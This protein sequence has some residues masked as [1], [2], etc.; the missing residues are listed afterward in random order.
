MTAQGK[1]RGDKVKPVE[2]TAAEVLAVLKK[3][4]T[5]TMTPER[6]AIF[7]EQKIGTGFGRT[8]AQAMDAWVIF[9]WP[10][11]RNLRMA[12]EIKVSRSDFKA[13]IKNPAK[14]R[15]ALQ[16][17][18]EFWFL[19]PAGL[20]KPEEIPLDCGLMEVREY[21]GPGPNAKELILDPVVSAPTLDTCPPSWNFVAALARRITRLERKP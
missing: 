8:A 21:G 15:P 14:R 18:N 5:S 2:M 16:V 10:S 9:L 17:S 11:D 6:Y 1:G 20:I 13:E 19:A 3:T 7:D 12:F 4:Y